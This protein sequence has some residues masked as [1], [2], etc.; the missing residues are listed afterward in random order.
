MKQQVVMI[1]QPG[2]KVIEI[3]MRKPGEEVELL[4]VV[5]GKKAGLYKLRVV[6]DHKVGGTWGRVVIRGIAQKGA[7]LE[8]EGVIKIREGADKVD[9]FL[10][11]KILLLDK[12]SQAAVEPILEIEAD[13]VKASHAASVGRIEEEQLFYLMSRGLS[14]NQATEMIV[15]GFLGEVRKMV[16]KRS[17]SINHEDDE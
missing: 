3:S 17:L 16:D 14:R 1:N 5:E 13:E 2:E 15:E 10:Q 6:V 11:I 7:R 4:G 8:V 9:D 12:N